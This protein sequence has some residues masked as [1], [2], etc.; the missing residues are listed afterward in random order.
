MRFWESLRILLAYLQSQTKYKETTEYHAW[1]LAF[2]A[3]HSR[4][5]QH[6][7]CE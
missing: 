4:R 6:E 1:H 5:E 2:I 7:A 3:L